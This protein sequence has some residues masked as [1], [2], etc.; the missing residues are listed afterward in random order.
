[1]PN[2]SSHLHPDPAV[3]NEF[4]S[5]FWSSEAW[6]S[7]QPNEDEKLRAQAITR[8]IDE[9]VTPQ[10]ADDPN[11]RILDLGC[12]RGWLTSILSD[13]GT[14]LGIDPVPAAIERAKVLFPN[15]NTRLAETVD[16]ISEGLEAQFDLIVSSEVIEHIVQGQKESFL[17]DIYRLLKPG[18]FAILTTPRGELWKLWSSMGEP[19]QPVEEWITETEMRRLCESVQ[20]R[21][22][23]RDRVFLPDFPFDW[24]SRIAAR[25]TR[26][27]Y[28]GLQ[29][30]LRYHR[31][32]YQVILLSRDAR[33]G[34]S[35]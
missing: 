7:A 8:L 11:L 20:F 9:F 26:L 10:Q 24:L 28:L 14:V 18:G 25:N 23:A 33:D 13:Y 19:G 30:K 3:V 5:R 31:A 15:L 34:D 35:L 6:G 17:R 1:M 4:Y 32:I 29:E 22:V 21:V 2:L 16:L 27:R 12:G